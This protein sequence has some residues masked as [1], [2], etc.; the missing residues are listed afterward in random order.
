MSGWGSRCGVCPASVTCEE[1]HLAPEVRDGAHIAL[2]CRN[3]VSK[4]PVARE[5]R[6]HVRAPRAA[7]ENGV[8]DITDLLRL[9]VSAGRACGVG[10]CRT[11]TGHALGLRCANTRKSSARSFGTMT[12]LACKRAAKAG[13]GRI[14]AVGRGCIARAAPARIQPPA[15]PCGR[16]TGPRDTSGALLPVWMTRPAAR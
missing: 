10:R 9:V 16:A 14:R 4:H 12:R 2:L 5:V 3:S 1:A 7:A 8:A 11:I 15:P 6:S 13:R